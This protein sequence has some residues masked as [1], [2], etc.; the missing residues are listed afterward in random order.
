[1]RSF[2][3]TAVLA[4][5]SALFVLGAGSASA[6]PLLGHKHAGSGGKC[7]LSLV[8]EP[9]TIAI[10]EKVEIFGQLLCLGTSGEG[11][12]VTIY[13]QTGPSK[14]VLKLL[15]SSAG[16]VLGTATT[17][18]GGFYSFTQADVTDNVTFFARALGARS[19]DKRVRITPVLSLKGPSEKLPLLT[20]AHNRVTFKG[21]VEPA[22][23]GAEV[24]LQR[25][26]ATSGEEWHVIQRGFVGAGGAY[27]FSHNFVRP[28]D[29][30]IRVV[31]RPHG[32]FTV[33][34]IS[35]PL[36][37][38]ISQAEHPDLTINTTSY[39]I[40][41]GAP[42]TLSGVLKEGAGKTVTL[43]AHTAGTAFAPVTTAT[44]TG[45][46]EYKFVVTPPQNTSYRVTT[47]P[48]TSA[49]LFEG[50]RYILTAADSAHSVQTGQPL[51][52]A[53]TVTP[54]TF[55]KTVYL[56]REN[57]F[58]GGFHVV[59]VGSVA[60]GGTYSLTDYVF[61]AGSY[62]FRVKVPGDPNNQGAVSETFPVTVTPAPP[63]SLKPEIQPKEPTEGTV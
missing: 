4:A 53:G 54:G 35:S 60:S 29:A 50:V 14:G 5:A 38:G 7:R 27:S 24:V 28:G 45:G 39:S 23:E 12:T 42:V 6:V 26:N 48:V 16:T 21:I 63:A 41:Y 43:E 8:A 2:R 62:V 55:G 33:R 40:P 59:E 15:G 1:M 17:G 47:G 31:V 51:T 9:H 61:G 3:L 13:G 57:N 11:Q 10:G 56:E 49:V 46:G 37:Y 25:Q 52:F 32:K 22:D 18:A 34:G 19:A 20:G 30:N 58:G 44:T 36:S